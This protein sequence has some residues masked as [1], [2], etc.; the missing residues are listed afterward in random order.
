MSLDMRTAVI[1]QGE[2]QTEVEPKAVLQQ[3]VEQYHEVDL[4]GVAIDADRLPEILSSL[5]KHYKTEELETLIQAVD[6]E[7]TGKLDLSRAAQIIIYFL[8][9]EAERQ[10]ETFLRVTLK[11]S[12]Q[13]CIAEDTAM[14]LYYFYPQIIK[15]VDDGQCLLQ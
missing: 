10:K 2:Y 6:C 13:I 3:I 9:Q 8:K 7:G 15:A 1:G 11:I 4:N 14:I 12:A 5:V